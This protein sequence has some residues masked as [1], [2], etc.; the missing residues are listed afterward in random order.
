V[1]YLG[2][3][4]GDRTLNYLDCGAGWRPVFVKTHKPVQ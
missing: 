1:A 2:R 4:E 3:E